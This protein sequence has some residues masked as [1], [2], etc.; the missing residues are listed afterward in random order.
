M[1]GFVYWLCWLCWLCVGCV[2]W[3]CVRCVWVCWSCVGCVGCVRLLWCRVISTL[4]CLADLVPVASQIECD[5][6]GQLCASK[7]GLATHQRGARCVSSEDSESE[8]A[9]DSGERSGGRGRKRRK[10]A[11]RTPASAKQ[12]QQKQTRSGQQTGLDMQSWQEI[13]QQQQQQIN[14]LQNQQQSMSMNQ[15]TLQAAWPYQQPRQG[16]W[17]YQQSP[18]SFAQPT[19]ALPTVPATQWDSSSMLSP[20]MMQSVAFGLAMGQNLS[21]PPHGGYPQ[22]PPPPWSRNMY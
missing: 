11:Y 14:Q 16:A 8:G 7:I 21:R 18:T 19:H 15:Q 17:P 6:C 20:T 9:S 2:F 3:L 5:R 1:F 22:Y 10:S 13:V 4:L 12:R